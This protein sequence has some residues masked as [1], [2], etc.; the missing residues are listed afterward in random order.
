MRTGRTRPG[1]CDA[2]TRT[3]P[4]STTR[5]ARACG[6]ERWRRASCPPIP[7][8]GSARCSGLGPAAVADGRS[9]L[10]KTR[11]LIDADRTR[12]RVLGPLD[13]LDLDLREIADR[14]RRRLERFFVRARGAGNPAV[15]DEL[16]RVTEHG[17]R[18]RAASVAPS[19][20][21]KFMT[22]HAPILTTAATKALISP[23][24]MTSP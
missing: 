17:N 16:V 11:E 14:I 21:A 13:A 6:N 4:R 18:R 15:L 7:K 1:C 24:F 9:Q 2:R 20:C 8:R 12:A 10:P 23:C 5:R 22:C 19:P 3:R